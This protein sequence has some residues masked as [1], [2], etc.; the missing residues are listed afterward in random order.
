[1][2]VRSTKKEFFRSRVQITMDT[3]VEDKFDGKEMDLTERLDKMEV[4][5]GLESEKILRKHEVQEDF[6]SQA[7]APESSTEIF[8]T[9]TTITEN[10]CPEC[11]WLLSSKA[12]KCPRCGTRVGKPRKDEKFQMLREKMMEEKIEDDEIYLPK[13]EEPEIDIGTI[14]D[15]LMRAK[16]AFS[17]DEPEPEEEISIGEKPPMKPAETEAVE[18]KPDTGEVSVSNKCANCGWLLSSKATKC[19]RCGTEVKK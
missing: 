18:E 6:L 1:M 12:R 8:S 10:R 9:S 16:R 3:I 2:D 14:D 17:L 15:D 19:P 7:V 11:G 5:L 13:K 4:D